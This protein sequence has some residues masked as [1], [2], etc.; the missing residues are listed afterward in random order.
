MKNLTF[1][2]L[3]CIN[4]FGVVKDDFLAL[5]ELAEHLKDNKL[6]MSGG[7]VV[8]Q[9][10]KKFA[11]ISKIDKNSINCNSSL[12]SLCIYN[13]KKNEILDI[14]D[15]SFVFFKDILISATYWIN[16]SKNERISNLV[17]FSKNRFLKSERKHVN[18]ERQRIEINKSSVCDKL[19]KSKNYLFHRLYYQNEFV[20]FEVKSQPIRPFIDN[21]PK[22]FKC[23]ESYS[24][25]YVSVYFTEKY[26]KI[27]LHHFN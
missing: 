27:L 20:K 19:T 15:F 7:I 1:L 2:F 22:K 13:G 21:D 12:E 25:I 26:S 4:C 24:D 8:G 18:K 3:L 11:K 23:D 6:Y 10:F 9:S 16:N 14:S 5:R 17:G